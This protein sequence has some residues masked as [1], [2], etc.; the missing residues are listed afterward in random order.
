MT[1][2]ELMLAPMRKELTS[3]GFAELRSPQDVDAFMEANKDGTALL[4]VNSI[5]GCAAGSL[6]P[7]LARALASAPRPQALATVF[8][9]QDIEATERARQLFVGYSPSSPAAALFK[10]GELVMMLERHQIQGRPP[11]MLAEEL[12]ASFTRVFGVGATV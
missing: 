10:D 1:Y 5:C 4:V 9:G 3:L 8:A 2:S 7:A 12:G 11:A 6:R